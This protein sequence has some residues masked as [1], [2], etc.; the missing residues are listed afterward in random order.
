MISFKE[1][2]PLSKRLEMSKNISKKFPT[3]I[4]IILTTSSEDLIIEK[5]KYITE[6]SLQLAQFII[7]IRKY[8]SLKSDEA[9][10]LFMP[11]NTVPSS[12]ELL[13]N[14]Y[15]KYVDEDGFLYITVAK[16]STFG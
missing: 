14:L 15:K 16:E 9:V 1:K 11:D 3:K 4:G 12:T 6:N 7:L 10:F 8:I 2:N 13:S 5:D